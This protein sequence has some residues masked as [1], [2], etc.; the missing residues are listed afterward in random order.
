[1]LNQIQVLE[2]GILIVGLIFT[3]VKSLFIIISV[4]IIFSLLMVSVESK[5][6]E[7]GVMRMV[8]LEKVGIIALV[9]C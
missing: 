4:L 6:F 7:I 3:L 2:M 5:T 8:G 1:M 9:I